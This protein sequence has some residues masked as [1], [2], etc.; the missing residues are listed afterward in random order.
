MRAVVRIATRIV[1]SS[2]MDA[3]IAA[4]HTPRA[5]CRQSPASD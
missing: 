1:I 5:W 3:T 2:I 4:K